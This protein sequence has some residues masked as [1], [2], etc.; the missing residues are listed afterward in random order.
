MLS[1]PKG[2]LAVLLVFLAS[3]SFAATVTWIG[4]NGVNGNWSD[5]TKWSGGSTPSA[6]D[7]VT[8][9]CSCTVT[10]DTGGNLLNDATLTIE[11]GT[12]LDLN[13]NNL[14]ARLVRTLARQLWDPNIIWRANV[15]VS[16]SRMHPKSP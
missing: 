2:R 12:V 15:P 4:A 1:Y 3:Q 6:T 11:S 9:D 5:G 14:S 8:I 10:N 13:G 16:R 7:D